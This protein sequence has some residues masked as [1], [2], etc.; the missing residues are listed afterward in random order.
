MKISYKEMRNQVFEKPEIYDQFYDRQFYK[1]AEIRNDHHIATFCY[2]PTFLIQ[3]IISFG[4]QQTVT[5]MH[6]MISRNISADVLRLRRPETDFCETS[7][8]F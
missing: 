3:F 8:R 7:S 6:D 5:L 1:V 2:Y 4:I